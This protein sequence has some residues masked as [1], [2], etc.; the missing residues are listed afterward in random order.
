MP[1]EKKKKK[2]KKKKK[3][4]GGQAKEEENTH[5]VNNRVGGTWQAPNHVNG[6]KLAVLQLGQRGN[7]RVQI[8]CQPIAH[9][10]DHRARVH[11]G[12]REHVA[13]GSKWEWTR[14]TSKEEE[15]E[16]EEK[17]EEEE[18]DRR[19]RRR[20]EKEEKKMMRQ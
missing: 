9:A 2:K 10:G 4:G 16:E 8:G 20:Q 13:L 12:H 1:L 3:G 14:K 6:N 5:S 7:H 15:E 11:S 19:R 17:E 18:E